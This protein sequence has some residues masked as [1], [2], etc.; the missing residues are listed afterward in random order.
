M[1]KR[2]IFFI[3]LTICFPMLAQVQIIAHRGASY[4]APE[5][6]VASAKLAWELGTDAVEVD[7]FL[8]KDNRIIGIHDPTARR[9]SGHDYVIMDTHSDVLRTLEVGSFKDE[10]Y[11]GEKIPF[12]EEIIQTIPHGKEL[13]VEV[14]L[15]E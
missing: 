7:I 8:S 4:L 14:K 1:K 15:G 3:L 12:L 5:N 2:V 9:T 11:R 13:V 6:T 10:K